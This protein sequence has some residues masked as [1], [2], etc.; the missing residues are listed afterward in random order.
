MSTADNPAYPGPGTPRLPARMNV[1]RRAAA[2]ARIFDVLATVV[3]IFGGLLTLAQVVGGIAF[4]VGWAGSG[5]SGSEFDAFAFF[6]PLGTF[7]G[8]IT[9]VIVTAIT[10]AVITLA[11]A[12]AGYVAQ[13]SPNN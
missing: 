13:R 11:T 10:W 1:Q 3:L 8:A 12:V 9:T 5:S 4:L 2:A 6:V 7:V